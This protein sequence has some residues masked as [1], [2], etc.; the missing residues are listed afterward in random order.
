HDNLRRRAAGGAD[1]GRDQLGQRDGLQIALS[2]VDDVDT[3]RRGFR[4]LLDGRTQAPIRDEADRHPP[5]PSGLRRTGPPSDR[6]LGR[7]S[8]MMSAM[9]AARLTSPMPV[10]PPRT[11]SFTSQGEIAGQ[12]RTK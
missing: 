7:R 10:T 6:G 8:G 11:K 4:R 9:P 3:R 2:D 5:S 12:W 1:D